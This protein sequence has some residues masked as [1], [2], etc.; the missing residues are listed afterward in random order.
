MVEE[1]GKKNSRKNFKGKILRK[2][3][4]NFK[5]S[6][7]KDFEI[8]QILNWKKVENNSKKNSRGESLKFS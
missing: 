1:I 6:F 4:K 8:F 3:E 5:D 2:L 7:Q